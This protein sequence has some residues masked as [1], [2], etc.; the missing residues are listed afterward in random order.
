M[1]INLTELRDEPLGKHPI[2]AAY[3]F[4]VGNDL[5]SKTL[6]LPTTRAVSRST[7]TVLATRRWTR[8][9][10]WRS[11]IVRGG[12]LQSSSAVTRVDTQGRR[13]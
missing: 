4:A 6:S 10:Q 11:A 13:A 1:T 9:P 2:Q 8:D 7:S 3:V 12:L 5:P